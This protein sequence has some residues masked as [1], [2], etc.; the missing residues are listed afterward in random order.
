MPPP[1]CNC[2]HFPFSLPPAAKMVH[3]LPRS[4]VRFGIR[5]QNTSFSR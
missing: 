3:L 4:E 2:V 1:T 5:K